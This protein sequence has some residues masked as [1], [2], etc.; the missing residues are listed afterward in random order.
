MKFINPFKQLRYYQT[1][2]SKQ[3]LALINAN[4]HISELIAQNYQQQKQITFLQN[5]L[6]IAEDKLKVNE[7]MVYAMKGERK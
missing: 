7:L 5:S 1:L 3:C 6:K 2:C 4:D